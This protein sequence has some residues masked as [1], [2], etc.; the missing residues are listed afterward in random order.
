[1]RVPCFLFRALACFVL[2]AFVVSALRLHATLSETLPVEQRIREAAV[3]GDADGADRRATGAFVRRLLDGPGI[4]ALAA[5]GIAVLPGYPSAERAILAVANFWG[6]SSL[7]ELDGAS[8]G[9]APR[10]VQ[11]FATKSAHD[12][13]VIHGAADGGGSRDAVLVAAEYE[14]ERS[15]VYAIN[16]SSGID[17]QGGGRAPR[18]L[19]GWPAC[20]DTDATQCAQWA[21]SGWMPRVPTSCTRR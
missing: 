18:P 11:Q 4:P 12:W 13:E 3:A 19:G 20:A 5:S 15:L 14:A 2:C 17:G 8:L 16:R 7:Y 6:E 21:R 1:M 10:L 9:L